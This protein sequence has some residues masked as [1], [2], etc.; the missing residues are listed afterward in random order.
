MFNEIKLL[1]RWVI[2]IILFWTGVIGFFIF[3]DLYHSY[4]Y[5]KNE[6][7]LKAKTKIQND[8]DFRQW[9]ASHGGVYVPI[10]KNTKPNLYLAHL[11]NRD[12]ETFDNQH[13]TLINPAYALR[14]LLTQ[15]S[16]NKHIDKITSN[17]LLNP[18]NAPD[19][20]EKKALNKVIKSEKPYYEFKNDELRYLSPFK[21]N[22]SCLKCHAFQG[23]RVGDIRGAISVTIDTKP[24]ITKYITID[25]S[26]ILELFLLWIAGLIFTFIGYK[27]MEK[28]ILERI[29]MYE[30]GIYGLVDLVEQRDTYTA[31]HSKRVA[32]Y[33]VMIAKEMGYKK[34]TL[35]LL[36]K[37]GMLHDIGKIVTPDAVLLK[38]GK[39]TKN[40]FELIQE[41]VTT[42]YEFLKNMDAYKN[43]AEI[44]RYHHEKYDGTGYVEGIKGDEIPILS[45]I[46]AV[47][48]AF[49]AMTTNR[50]YKGRKDVATALK[51]IKELSGKQFNPKVAEAAQKALKNVKVKNVSQLPK[52]K[53]EMERFVYFFKDSLTDCFNQKYLEF[54]LS[55]NEDD[56]HFNYKY[57]VFIYLHNFGKYNKE[58]GWKNGDKELARIAKELQHIFSKGIIFREEGDDFII[59]SKEK[60]EIDKEKLDSIVVNSII[61]IDY[62]EKELDKKLKEEILNTI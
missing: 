43:I 50:I 6:A 18:N 31:G 61:S 1:K 26:Y 5:A 51:E 40:E 17:I 62:E 21:V 44:I 29:K 7:L 4:E 27:K 46:Q 37:A 14:Q 54:V 11:K 3:Y 8:I 22:K 47:A 20:W 25:R 53:L 52:T 30:E 45:A 36:Y 42:G 10:D 34:E 41:H 16:F 19:M 33:S 2:Y 24:F 13:L 60:I 39:L 32:K 35:D 48:D 15:S 49:D 56:E 55:N 59:L 58:Y 9:I 12:I 57:A 28:S 23:Y 38:P